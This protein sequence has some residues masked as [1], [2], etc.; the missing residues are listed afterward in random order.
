MADAMGFSVW[1]VQRLLQA[2]NIQWWHRLFESWP[3]IAD[4]ANPC[5]NPNI[6]GLQACYFGCKVKCDQ[7]S[8]SMVKAQAFSH[9]ITCASM[10]KYVILS[11]P[12]QGES[13]WA[14]GL[15]KNAQFGPFPKFRLPKQIQNAWAQ[16]LSVKVFYCI[17]QEN[18]LKIQHS[19][20]MADPRHPFH[21]TIS[22]IKITHWF[23][24][25][26]DAAWV[27]FKPFNDPRY[28]FEDTTWE[29]SKCNAWWLSATQP[30]CGGLQ[31]AWGITTQ[32][33][34]QGKTDNC[35]VSAGKGTCCSV[36]PDFHFIYIL[37]YPEVKVDV[38]DYQTQILNVE[39]IRGVFVVKKGVWPHIAARSGSG[40]G[41]NSWFGHENHVAGCRFNAN[42]DL[43]SVT[44][45]VWWA[46]VVIERKDSQYINSITLSNLHPHL[47]S[48]VLLR[49]HSFVHMLS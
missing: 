31:G 6:F 15:N 34:L 18:P 20:W 40:Q 19:Q 3:L 26:F 28:P 17:S 21:D 38:P 8:L 24:W 16:P 4:L 37:L 48:T 33:S 12:N 32:P 5:L 2:H 49:Y 1:W 22:N 36:C 41:S 47:L 10:G 35:I 46:G 11:T 25:V 23:N 30:A 44:I 14:Q 29:N 42:L 27:T 45:C 43:R 39:S 9:A 13:A 7:A